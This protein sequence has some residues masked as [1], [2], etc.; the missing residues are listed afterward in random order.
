M[1]F[2]GLQSLIPKKN[3]QSN[4]NKEQKSSLDLNLSEKPTPSTK[5]SAPS[6]QQSRRYIFNIEVEKI[7]SNPYQPRTSNDQESI[8]EL[9]LSINEH[10]LLQPVIVTKKIRTTSSGEVDEYELISGHRRLAAAKIAG[11][12]L[13]SAIV[14]DKNVSNQEKLELAL[15]ENIQRKN[16]NSMEQAKA[17]SRLHTE[18]G[19][20]LDEIG[21]R[22]GKNKRTISQTISLL[23]LDPKIQQA[24][25]ENQIT[26]GQAR[27]LTTLEET[28][29]KKLFDKII[30]ENLSARKSEDLVR[31]TKKILVKSYHR[32]PRN[33]KFEQAAQQIIDH[34][35]IP[36]K[37][38]SIR[39][40]N[41]GK[42][43]I[44]FKNLEE[45]NK[46]VQKITSSNSI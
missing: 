14:Q 18:F 26:E 12:N 39:S 35:N 3:N 21:K 37:I 27:P 45:L 10:G 46:L 22:V 4:Q 5:L 36:V 40:S 2:Q 30:K 29:Q 16:L 8:N 34:L 38:Q 28:V 7:K 15:I 6:A 24:I 23:R 17:F 9:A 42:I 1:T 43:I 20:T 44:Q 25:T 13:I 32:S 11:L 31:E 19:L 41:G 33:Q